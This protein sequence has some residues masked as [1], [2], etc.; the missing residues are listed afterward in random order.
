MPRVR[1]AFYRG[2]VDAIAADDAPPAPARRLV[3]RAVGL[4]LGLALPTAVL[5]WVLGL[6]AIKQRINGRLWCSDADE[7]AFEVKVRS[8]GRAT[9]FSDRL[10]CRKDGALIRTIGDLR[11][12][13]TTLGI[14][15]G[16]SLLLLGL[17][18]VGLW[19][20]GRLRRRL[21]AI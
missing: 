12:T 18:V 17:L 21:P 11:M 7:T 13:T 1:V 20:Y 5:A 2:D 19:T 8:S 10:L 16:I 14:A 4:V 15:F 6:D 3:R 9:R